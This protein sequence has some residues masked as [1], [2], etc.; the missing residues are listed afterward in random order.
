[1]PSAY[2]HL[3]AWCRVMCWC[4]AVTCGDVFVSMEADASWLCAYDATAQQRH[5][6]KIARRQAAGA[7][8]IQPIHRWL[9][10]L[11]AAHGVAP[12]ARTLAC[13]AVGS[14]VPAP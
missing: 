12:Q 5:I 3:A 13:C 2:T 7:I 8:T 10:L 6:L 14:L 4:R 11:P 1:M 9:L